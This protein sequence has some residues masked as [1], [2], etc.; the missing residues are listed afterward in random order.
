MRK[1]LPINSREVPKANCDADHTDGAANSDCVSAL[2]LISGAP[3]PAKGSVNGQ[4][5]PS[6]H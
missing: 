5:W 2:R 3:V 6:G 4:F 1:Q